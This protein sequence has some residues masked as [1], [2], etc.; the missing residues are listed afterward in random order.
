M[1]QAII[2]IDI[3]TTGTKT[4][5]FDVHG[6]VL[7]AAYREY[8]CT[9]PRPNWVEQNGDEIFAHTL[10]GA[11]EAVARAGVAPDAVV[12]IG[13]S[14]QRAT[15]GLCEADGRGIGPLISWQDNRPTEQVAWQQARI[16]PQ[17]YFE[18]T[19]LPYAPTWALAKLLWLR[20]HQAEHYA[21]AAKVVLNQEQFLRRLGADN[22]Y[23]DWSNASLHGLLDLSSRTWSDELID[24][25][26]V[27]RE[28]LPTI[29]PSATQIGTVSPEI[30]SRLGIS[31]HTALCTGGG[32]QQCAMVG[33]GVIRDGLASI[34][35]GTAGLVIAYASSPIRDPQQRAMSTVAASNCDGA[36]E[37]EGLQLGA[38]GVFR[39]YRDELSQGDV[40]QAQAEG[41]EAYDRITA[42]ASTA[43][44]GGNGLIFLPHLA[45]SACPHW[46]A[47]ARGVLAGLTF[48]HTRR[49][50]ARAVIEGITFE[51]REIIEMLEDAGA[52]IEEFRVTGGATKSAFWNGVQADIYGRPISTLRVPDATILGAALLG[53]VGA[54]LFA[55]VAEG[56][57]QMVQTA[58]TIEPHADAVR[59]YEPYYQ[60]FRALYSA[61][62]ASGAYQAFA[63]L[64]AEEIARG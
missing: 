38:A 47:N 26:G 52:R 37:I 5:V 13:L 29:V 45:G 6:T 18:I 9:Y 51:V 35:L 22:F 2:G 3:G 34:T 21:R 40:L 16:S 17:R 64:Q 28:K 20:E 41:G 24:A 14:T 57:A 10:D 44:P 58:E 12:S 43:P 62:A 56:V 23:C 48:A 27:E 1:R 32:D 49:D 61:L 30:A 63:A 11:A 4:M 25:F 36:Y 31:P 60:Q 19:G 33:A 50:I 54:G 8:G 55:S 39:W 53:A 59:A 7:G 46:N 42:G 15:V